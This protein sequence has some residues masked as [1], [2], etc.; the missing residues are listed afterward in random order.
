MP[1]MPRVGGGG[2]MLG[3][4]AAGITVVAAAISY[5]FV[6]QPIRRRGFRG[7]FTAFTASTRVSGF[8]AVGVAAVGMLVLATGSTT[9][10]SIV[11]S[12]TQ[13]AA[14]TQIEA[15]QKAVEADRSEPPTPEESE[16]PA[17]PGGDQI[18][19]IGD[20]VMLASAQELQS[21]FPGIYIDAVVSRQLSQAPKIV[22][23]MLAAGK[24]RPTVVIGLGT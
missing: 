14:Q 18:T 24:L 19:A 16:P 15:G 13:G 6:E 4:I 7:S 5:R 21:A 8:R 23:S 20:S 9:V 10:A 22:E 12:P 2:W 1:E 17:L 3:G 11:A